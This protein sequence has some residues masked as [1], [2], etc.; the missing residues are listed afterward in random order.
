MRDLDDAAAAVG[1]AEDQVAGDVGF[2]LLQSAQFAA[3]RLELASAAGDDRVQGG[4]LLR[5]VEDGE[6]GLAVAEGFGDHSPLAYF[7]LP[8]LLGA[9]GIDREHGFGQRVAQLAGRLLAGLVQHLRL[10]GQG[11]FVGERLDRL[12]D[13]LRLELL[14]P[15]LLQGFHRLRESIGQCAGEPQAPL[16]RTVG[17]VEQGGNLEVGEFITLMHTGVVGQLLKLDG[18]VVA[19][20]FVREH[21]ITQKVLGRSQFG[22]HHHNHYSSDP[23]RQIPRPTITRSCIAVLSLPS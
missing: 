13:E 3:H 14:D 12:A 23:N 6:G 19:D 18:L 10:H 15:S 8:A 5:G 4:D 2:E 9:V 16:R 7:L 20:E 1:L 22:R 11:V 17:G 21:R